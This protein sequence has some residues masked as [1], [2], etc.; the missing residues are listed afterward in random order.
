MLPFIV[1]SLT[2]AQSRS[3]RAAQ[4]QSAVISSA[5]L[6]PLTE[7]DDLEMCT[8]LECGTQWWPANSR[9][10]A[11]TASSTTNGNSATT[12]TTT[13][14]TTTIATN[15]ARGKGATAQAGGCGD[16]LRALQ[17]LVED[18]RAQLSRSQAVVRGLQGR[19]RTCSCSIS[20]SGEP[21]P[22]TPRKVNWGDEEEEDEGWQSSDGGG[23]QL[24]E[25][26]CRVGALEDQLR[27]G[28]KAA[29]VTPTAASAAGEE[30]ATKSSSAATTPG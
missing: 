11:H 18:L 16:E 30:D 20:A 4:S 17:R 12:T 3:S 2:I 27:N 14:A 29:S 21:S 8:S 25:L 28:G 23:G 13:T 1:Q 6:P 10:P 22:V 19:L 26:V 7:F 15:T 24:R 5:L 9:S